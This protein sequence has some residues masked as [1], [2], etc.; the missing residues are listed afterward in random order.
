MEFRFR[1]LE[2]GACL[3]SLSSTNSMQGFTLAAIK[4]MEKHLNSIL[5]L[6]Y[7]R[8][9]GRKVYFYIT[10]CYKMNFMFLIRLAKNEIK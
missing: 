1:A 8:T 9:S 3:K 4:G 5:D 7:W 6:N 10:P 2:Q